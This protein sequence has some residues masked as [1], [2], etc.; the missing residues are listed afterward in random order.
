MGAIKK[1]NNFDKVEEFKLFPNKKNSSIYEPRGGQTSREK[2]IEMFK[3]KER[4][5]EKERSVDR[6]EH[7]NS[8][9]LTYHNQHESSV[10]AEEGLNKKRQELSDQL[11]QISSKIDQEISELRKQNNAAS[12][13]NSSSLAKKRESSGGYPS[14]ALTSRAKT[15]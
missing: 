5:A 12:G 2:S 6:S 15:Q 4:T 11:K 9:G 10:N 8:L 1:D 14:S 13:S 3:E 7:K